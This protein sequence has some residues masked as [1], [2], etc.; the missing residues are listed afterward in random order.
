MRKLLTGAY[1]LEKRLEKMCESNPNKKNS[2]KYSLGKIYT[3]CT[4][5][6]NCVNRSVNAN[7]DIC[8]TLA[9]INGNSARCLSSKHVKLH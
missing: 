3:I 4:E 5:L 2:F 9:N 6:E 7:I 8:L 1:F